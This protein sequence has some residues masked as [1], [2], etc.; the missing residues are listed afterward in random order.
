MSED[1]DADNEIQINEGSA[2][3]KNEIIVEN[4]KISDVPKEEQI[5]LDDDTIFQFSC[6]IK[7][8]YLHL[9]LNEIGVFCPFIYEKLLSLEQM[10]DYNS[11]F[12]SCDNLDE[13]K[14]HIDN[15]FHNNLIKLLKK[16]DIIALEVTLYKI[17]VKEKF[18]IDLNKLM[19][20]KKDETLI[21][22]YDDQKKDKKIFKELETYLRSKNLN[23][24]LKKFQE[25]KIKNN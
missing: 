2:Y 3:P 14:I 15:L 12:E 21:A 10:K 19:T 7:N 6:Y 1:S 20:T 5:K 23:D 4:K 8:G 18:E 25:I 17:C 11:A 16:R 22:L 24:I 13:V 9:K